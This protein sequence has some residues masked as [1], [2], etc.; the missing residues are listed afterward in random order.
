MSNK[1]RAG[2]KYWSTVWE[3]TPLQPPMNT[4]S[5]SVNDYGDS[6][7]FS[8]FRRTFSGMNTTNLNLLEI[9]CGNSVILPIFAKKFGFSISGLDYSELGCKQSR[10]ILERENIE[11]EIILGDAFNPSKD[12][13]GRF[14]VVCSFGVVEHFEDT[15]GTIAAFAKFLKPGG[16]LITSIPN[17]KGATGWLHKWLNRPVYNI[18]VPLD[19]YDMKKALSSA[20]LNEKINEYFLPISFAIT[21]YSNDGTFIPYYKLK[22]VLVKTIRYFSKLIWMLEIHIHPL[23]ARKYFSG[24]VYTAAIKPL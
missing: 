3:N 2:E 22:K 20:G 8:L 9:G 1:D 6:I 5:K 17:M 10:M 18:H 15:A 7:L 14:D 12:L 24:G 11:G 4:E 16:I 19:I 13:I 23:P 21:L